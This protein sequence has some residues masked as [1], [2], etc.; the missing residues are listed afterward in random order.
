METYRRYTTWAATENYL[1]EQVMKKT[2]PLQRGLPDEVGI[3]F[4]PA[5]LIAFVGPWR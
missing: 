2:K 5:F 4:S 3:S 1:T